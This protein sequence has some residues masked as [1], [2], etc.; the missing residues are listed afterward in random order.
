[1]GKMREMTVCS[2]LKKTQ[3]L[4]SVIEPP[5]RQK[6]RRKHGVGEGDTNC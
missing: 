2:V 6:T 4:F 3:K 5:V 1:M